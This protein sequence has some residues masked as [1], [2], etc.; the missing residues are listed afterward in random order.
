MHANRPGF[1]DRYGTQRRSFWLSVRRAE[2]P[3]LPQTG[4]RP[5]SCCT[6]PRWLRH[7]IAQHGFGLRQFIG[8]ESCRRLPRRDQHP[9]RDAHA[10]QPGLSNCKLVA[11]DHF[12]IPSPLRG[13]QQALPQAACASPRIQAAAPPAVRSRRKIRTPPRRPRPATTS[14]T[15]SRRE[16]ASNPRSD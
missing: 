11:Y 13:D 2:N 5:S 10:L 8:N 12:I 7:G 9:A 16:A 1:V 6:T 14:R 3:A 4:Y 15:A